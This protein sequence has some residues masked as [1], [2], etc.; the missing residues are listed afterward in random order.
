[1]ITERLWNREFW[2][3]IALKRTSHYILYGCG[4]L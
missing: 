1:M 2:A 3:D 4:I